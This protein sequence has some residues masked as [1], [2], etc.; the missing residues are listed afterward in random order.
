MDSYFDESVNAMVRVIPAS[1]RGEK[2]K[3]NKNYCTSRTSWRNMFQSTIKGRKEGL[4]TSLVNKID[5][6][7]GDEK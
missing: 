3:W 4:E 1:K 6:M 2:A 5:K 7:K